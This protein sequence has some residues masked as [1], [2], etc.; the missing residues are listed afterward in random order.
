MDALVQKYWVPD[1]QKI[2]V[3]VDSYHSGILQ[4]HFIGSDQIDRPFDSLSQFLL[5]MEEFL[6]HNQAPQ[7]D[8][9]RRSFAELL[10]ASSSATSESLISKG[11]LATF[12]LQILF[13]QHSSWQ[14]TVLWK[15][16]QYRQSFR[17]VLELILLMDSALREADRKTD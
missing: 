4:G 5:M 7:A 15:E 10:A 11:R 16:V 13:R 14:G 12:E 1:K 3:S 8:T 9:S 17:S 6:D 2:T